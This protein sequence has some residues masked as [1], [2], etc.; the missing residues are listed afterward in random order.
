MTEDGSRYNFDGLVVFD[1]ANN[2]QGDIDH[3]CRIIRAMG[4]QAAKHGVKAAMKFQFRQLDTFIHKAHLDGSSNKHVSRFLSTRLDLD[5]VQK[6]FDE[7]KA[8]GLLSMCTP[9]DEESVDVIQDMGFDILKIASCSA[10]DW[11]LLEKATGTGL[12]IVC[13]TGG[14]D[15]SQVDDLNSFFNHR[16]VDF[17]LMHCVSV[18]PTPA[19]ML[20]LNQIDLFRNRYPEP[21]IG[22]STHE[23][24]DSLGPVQVA[25]AKGAQLFER[26]VGISTD[27]IQ[28]NGYSSTPEQVDAWLGALVEA[29]AMCGGVARPEVSEEEREAL[30]T[31]ERGVYLREPVTAGEEVTADNIYFA[32]PIEPG[33]LASGRFRPG[34]V[35]ERD[36]ATDA[37][38]ALDGIALPAPPADHILKKAVHEVK[39]MLHQAE[40]HLNT[41]FK[42]EFSHHYGI[43]KFREVGAILIDIVNREYCKKII[44][45]LPGQVHPQHFHKRKEETFQVLNGTLN[46]TVDGRK[47]VLEPGDTCLVQPGMWHNFWT[48]TGCIFEEISTRH[49][50]DDSYYK[51]KSIN[52]MERAERKTIVNHWGRYELLDQ[53]DP[54]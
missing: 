43:E 3:G 51:D 47:R 17:A 46:V 33:Q 16:G 4:E 8:A 45:Q 26:H 18:Y 7:V 54:A 39:A 13:S 48:E 24:P 5:G 38:L 21:P 36:F 1:L 35:A 37:A 49:Y 40:V 23:D 20:E 10:A 12:P 22:W 41:D 28:L 30:L 14:L 6:L 53:I 32:M 11:P 34:I 31:L 29:R 52:A 19:N 42:I 44:V 50:N 15:L 27:T 2:H 25:V 9:F